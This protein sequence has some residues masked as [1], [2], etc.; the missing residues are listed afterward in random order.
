MQSKCHKKLE[1]SKFTVYIVLGI[2]FIFFSIALNG[3]GFIASGN[4]LNILR[5]T[6]MVS[7]MAVAGVFVLGA[8]QIDLTVGSTAAMSAMFSA[9]VLQAT[10]NMLLAIL[11]SILFGIFVGFINGLLVTKLK[12]PS[13]LATLGMMQMIRG[14]A[15]WITNTAAVPIK[16]QTFNTIFGTGYIGGVSVL[17]L[18]TIVFYIIGFVLFNKTRFGRHALATGGN[19]L[20][21]KYSGLKTEKI[22]MIIFM[23]SG[24]FAAFA[25]RMQS[26]RYSFGDGDEMSVIASVVLGGAA[27]SGGT[28]SMIGALAGSLLMGMINNALILAGLSSAQ[29]KI[30]NGAIIIFAVALSNIVQNKKRK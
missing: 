15:M 13:F 8:G 23:M 3:K 30:V 19:E 14:M 10:N 4:L 9:L 20:A 21:A 27:M 29:Q 22:K 5:Q 7:V 16:N 28:G 26:G 12:L 25:G 2:V 24:A 11:A 18:W 17:I 6:A 1:L